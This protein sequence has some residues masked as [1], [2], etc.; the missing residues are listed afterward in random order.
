MGKK[1][2][3]RTSRRAQERAARDL[4]RD[5]EK[6]AA[7]SPGGTRARPMEIGSASVVEPRI[8]SL[9]CPQCEGRYRVLDHRSVG[10]GI[11]EVDVRC[12]TCSMPRTLWFKLVSDE[13]N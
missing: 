11:R 10:S 9:A 7:L 5:R 2:P 3:E 6:L 4:V 13:P 8:N 1:R 12:T